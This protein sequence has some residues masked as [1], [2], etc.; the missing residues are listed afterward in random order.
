MRGIYVS[1]VRWRKNRAYFTEDP[2]GQRRRKK[3]VLGE[4]F[5]C[6][7]GHLSPKPKFL[8]SQDA[9]RFTLGLERFDAKRRRS[10]LRGCPQKGAQQGVSRIF[11]LTDSCLGS[12]ASLVTAI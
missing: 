3:E 9:H 4:I 10:H 5:V 6:M 7:M 8:I 1:N 11:Y 2:I 12:F